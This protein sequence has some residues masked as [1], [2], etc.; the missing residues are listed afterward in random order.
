MNPLRFDESRV[1]TLH[2]IL[3]RI[4]R[5]ELRVDYVGQNFETIDDAGSWSA[6]VG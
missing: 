6:E 5:E 2:S 4:L 1:Q 3:W